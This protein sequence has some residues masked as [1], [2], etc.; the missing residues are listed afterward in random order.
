MAKVELQQVTY[1]YFDQVL[2]SILVK[3]SKKPS[4]TSLKEVD[5]VA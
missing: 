2:D 4:P 1:T 3:F 5:K